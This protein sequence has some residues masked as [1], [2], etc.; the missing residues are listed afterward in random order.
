MTRPTSTLRMLL[1]SAFQLFSISAFTAAAADL[2]QLQASFMARYDEANA[3]RDESLKKL[4]ASYLA[5]LKKLEDRLKDTGDLDQVLPVREEISVV[6]DG[7]EDLPDL[8]DKPPAQLPGMRRKFVSARTKVVM[9]HARELLALVEKMDQ[10]LSEQETRLTREGDVD[11]A[12]AARKMSA[13]LEA[14]AGIQKARELLGK[15]SGHM[16]GGSGDSLPLEKFLPGTVWAYE[17]G[18]KDGS[19][20]E[21]FI[22]FFAGG[23][24]LNTLPN[25]GPGTWKVDGDKLA[26]T[27]NPYPTVLFTVGDERRSLNGDD[28][29]SRRRG[30]LHAVPVED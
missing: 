27:V 7:A 3:T 25:A 5:A 19:S 17:S 14:D 2:G 26:L 18:P 11:G 1:I 23:K 16:A 20:H 22:L 24:L 4:E 30:K 12:L 29:K 6:E 28:A 10:V 15:R 21:G 13:T 9:E 8:P